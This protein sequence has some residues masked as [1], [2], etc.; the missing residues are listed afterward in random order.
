MTPDNL[1]PPPLTPT[2]KAFPLWLPLGLFGI[3]FLAV[4]VTVAYY[5]GTRTRQSNLPVPTSTP[6]SVVA[7]NTPTTSLSISDSPSTSVSLSPTPSPISLVLG[8]PQ[9]LEHPT[10]IPSLDIFDSENKSCVSGPSFQHT[11]N[12]TDGSRLINLIFTDKCGMGDSLTLVRLIQTGNRFY[13]LSFSPYFNYW[14]KSS[15]LPATAAIDG[16]VTPKS[17]PTVKS[18]KFKP[19]SQYSDNNISYTQLKNPQL[20]DTTPYGRLYV[21]YGETDTYGITSRYFYLR[22]RDDTLQAYDLDPGFFT[23]DMI[24]QISWIDGTSNTDQFTYGPQNKCG[25]SSSNVLRPTSS[26]LLGLVE[27]GKTSTGSPVYRFSDPKNPIAVILYSQFPQE[28][29]QNGT[30][31]PNPSPEI[32]HYLAA[33]S[34]FLWQ[35]PL[36]DWHVYPNQRFIVQA[37]CGKPVIYLY[38]QKDTQVTVKVGANITQSEPQYPQSGWQ[39]LAHPNG[40]L[41]YQGQQYPYLFWEGKGFGPYP[42]LNNQGFVVP[43]SQLKSTLVSHLHQLGL[44][45][46]ESA[47]FLEFWLP[48]LPST[49]FVRLTWLDTAAMDRL[50]PLTVNPPPQTHIR[51]FLDFQGLDQPLNLTPQTL[52]A[53]VRRGFTL[54]E[55]GGLLI[56]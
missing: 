48:R 31:V 11:A 27:F 39:V 26:Q 47:D 19:A 29:Y 35:D 30:P 40:Q 52:T 1:P 17:L 20:I 28:T 23:D 24:P 56:K 43:Q 16:L 32:N 9:W 33:K 25:G 41:D 37:E 6:T 36:G 2:S 50:A 5:L 44:N 38:P 54:V 15:V 21:T 12:F 42:S 55:W 53:P 18:G 3:F 14:L 7:L 4:S 45:S 34:H 51:L 13:N 8:L 49:P 10:I 22:L 46:Q